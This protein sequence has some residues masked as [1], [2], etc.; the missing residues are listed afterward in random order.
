MGSVQEDNM[1]DPNTQS[2]GQPENPTPEVVKS[3]IA[4]ADLA[5]LKAFKIPGDRD[6]NRVFDLTSPAGRKEYADWASKGLGFEGNQRKLKQQLEDGVKK[7]VAEARKQWETERGQQPNPQGARKTVYDELANDPEVAAELQD[8]P[9]L[10]KVVR[11]LADKLD[12]AIQRVEEF[13]KKP[14]DEG[15]DMM[16]VKLDWRDAKSHPLFR[17]LAL[18]FGRARLSAT[19]DATR[20]QAGEQML[21]DEFAKF[22]EERGEYVKPGEFFQQLSQSYGIK[23]PDAQR[24]LTQQ[25]PAATPETPRPPAQPGRTAGPGVV[26]QEIDSSRMTDAEWEK[27]L[28]DKLGPGTQ[29][30]RNLYRSG[31]F[32]AREAQ[33]GGAPPRR[34][35]PEKH[36]L[37]EPARRES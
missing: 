18:Q 21:A 33:E 11:G 23:T 34:Y 15:P 3:A 31:N 25:P 24:P 16:E 10:Q 19:T 32:A 1:S 37:I 6:P 20:I 4:D 14:V 36:M 7:A 27:Y 30:L 13:G 12:A 8:A 2:N 29:N 5:E 22:C 9:V 28:D 26:A 17:E 35:D